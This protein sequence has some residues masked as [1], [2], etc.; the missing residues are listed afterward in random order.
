MTTLIQA[1]A[2]VAFGLALDVREHTA[3]L[4]HTAERVVPPGRVSGRLELG[5]SVC[6]R[7]RYFGFGWSL[8]A[9]VVELVASERFVDEQVRGP[10][11]SLRHE[12]RFT[13]TGAGTLLTDQVHWVS[14]FGLAG[15]LADELVVRRA[16][17]GVLT[18]R[19]AHLK[20]RAEVLSDHP[21][22][23]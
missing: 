21:G 12:H 15:R 16:L 10:F 18:A 20:R 2:E 4:A 9:Q 17:L 22:T 11:R 19:N 14:P 3:A 13:G 5:D 6:F 1:P 7:A 8:D 23:A